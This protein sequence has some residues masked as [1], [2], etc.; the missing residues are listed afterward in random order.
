MGQW[1]GIFLSLIHRNPNNVSDVYLADMVWP[2]HDAE[3]EFFLDIGSHLVE[4]NGMYLDRFN[5]WD[6]LDI[7]T[8]SSGLKITANVLILFIA[9]LLSSVFIY[10]K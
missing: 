4:K 3:S 9:L 10:L 2:K 7:N 5:V 6:S 1:F 8:G